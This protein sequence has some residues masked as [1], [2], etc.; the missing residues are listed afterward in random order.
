MFGIL[1]VLAMVGMFL[2]QTFRFYR[3]EGLPTG[4]PN[5]KEFLDFDSNGKRKHEHKESSCGSSC[6]APPSCAM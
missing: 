1:I 6:Y 2:F 4:P 3:K 5:P